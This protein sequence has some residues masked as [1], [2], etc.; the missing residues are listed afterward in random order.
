MSAALRRIVPVTL[1]VLTL[2][3]LAGPTAAQSRDPLPEV[4]ERL[5]IESQRVEKEI[6]DG[7]LRAYRLLCTDPNGSYDIIKSLIG[8]LRKDTSLS[9]SRR[10]TLGKTLERDIENLRALAGARRVAESTA[11]APRIEVRRTPDPRSTT[12]SRSAYDAA[13]SRFNSMS[14][15]VIESRGLR[16]KRGDRF[17]AAITQVDKSAVPSASDYEFPPDWLEKSKRRS[18]LAKLTAQERALLDALKKPVKIDYNMDTFQSVIDDLSKKLGQTI[19]LDKQAMEEAGVTYDSPITLRFDKPISARTALKRVLA[20]VGLT[21]VIRKENIQV[22]SNARAKEMLTTRTYYVGDLVGVVNPMYPA[23]ANQFQMVQAIGMLIS[24]IQ[25][26]DPE[27]W[28]G[29]GGPGSISFDPTRMSL[30]VKQS[31]EV[32]Y[33]LNGGR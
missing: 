16:E 8:M 9:E 29:R 30:V 24:Q 4:R 12:D 1:C 32:H 3:V 5:K 28:E 15:R 26:I 31:A 22:T 11:A 13:S 17:T 6:H 21:Y 20:D 7:R 33:M 27:S 2:G 19:L 14:G 18:P 10:E 23:I 25:N